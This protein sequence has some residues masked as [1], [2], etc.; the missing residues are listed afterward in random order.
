MGT[1]RTNYCITDRYIAGES[2]E[3]LARSAGIPT[4]NQRLWCGMKARLID[5]LAKQPGNHHRRNQHIPRSDRQK[6]I[7]LP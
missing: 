6:M 4:P 5:Y 7:A 1:Y 2:I 3:E